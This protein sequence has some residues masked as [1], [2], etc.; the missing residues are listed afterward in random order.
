M[1]KLNN[2]F[3]LKNGLTS[4]VVFA[5]LWFVSVAFVHPYYVS[6]TEI[7]HN[8]VKKTVEISCRMFTD[9]IENAIEKLNKTQLDLL[10]PKDRNEANKLLLDYINK[11]LVIKVN[12]KIITFK[13]IG[14]EKEEEAIWCYLEADNIENVKNILIE[15]SLLYDFLPAQINMMHITVNDK[16]QSTK[17]TNPEKKAEFNF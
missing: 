2:K 10:H 14:Y 16:R 4:T 6:V 12:Q 17:V 1:I 8:A 7:K 15:N 13:F 11:H 3:T 9:N 5:C